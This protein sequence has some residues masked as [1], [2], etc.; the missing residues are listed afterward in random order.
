MVLS[1]P[2]TP[3]R[4]RDETEQLTRDD[5]QEQLDSEAAGRSA[6]LPQKRS[7]GEVSTPP[8]SKVT[9]TIAGLAV[10]QVADLPVLSDPEAT[11][12]CLSPE[13]G[14]EELG[15]LIVGSIQ[16]GGSSP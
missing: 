10:C 12:A 14:E 2:K 9:R 7:G 4:P 8:D 6:T 1:T 3:K 11:V 15:A 16:Q 13:L 5:V